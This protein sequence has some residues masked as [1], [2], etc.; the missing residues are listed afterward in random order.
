MYSNVIVEERQLSFSFTVGVFALDSLWN[1]LLIGVEGCD[2]RNKGEEQ[3]S[4]RAR[5]TRRMRA[6]QACGALSLRRRTGFGF[7]RS[8]VDKKGF[9]KKFFRLAAA[10]YGG[11][12]FQLVHKFL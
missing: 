4:E 5:P 2:M 12:G 3:A 1:F 11:A 10:G 6:R 9:R 7:S 8:V